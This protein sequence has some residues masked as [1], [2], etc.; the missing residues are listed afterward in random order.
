MKRKGFSAD[1][2]RREAA[3]T[4]T[5]TVSEMSMMVTV[6][7]V[8][9]GPFAVLDWAIWSSC[10]DAESETVSALVIGHE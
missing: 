9:H 1:Q 10:P 8:S 2:L 6:S 5:V 3:A 4:R 7:S